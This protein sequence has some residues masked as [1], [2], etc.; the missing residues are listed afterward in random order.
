M[1][2]V[3][4]PAGA[5]MRLTATACPGTGLHHWDVRILTAT[6][7]GAIPR[8][9]YG[10]H[11]G[12]RDLDQRIDIPPQDVDCRIEIW[13]R[14]AAPS[15]W[16][17]D[18]CAIQDDTPEELRVGFWDAAKPGSKPDDVI[19]SF[20]IGAPHPRPKTKTNIGQGSEEIQSRDS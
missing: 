11:I 19:L 6:D 1:H 14:H 16:E 18:R 9:T 20:A 3:D 17:D 12:E 13:S 15:G 10:S 4:L 5:R 8:L 7:E 2:S